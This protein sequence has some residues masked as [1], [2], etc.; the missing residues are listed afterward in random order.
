MK[1]GRCGAIY[2]GLAHNKFWCGI[3][4]E[5]AVCYQPGPVWSD[6]SVQHCLREPGHKGP[7][8]PMHFNVF[9]QRTVLAYNFDRWDHER[10]VAR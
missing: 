8:S 5:T 9:D 10:G 3:C 4:L 6:G 7:C 2:I 1:C